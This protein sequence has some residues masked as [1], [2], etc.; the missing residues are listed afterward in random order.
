MCIWK[1]S[2]GLM[3]Q[4]HYYHIKTKYDSKSKLFLTDTDSS[5][6]EIKTEDIYENFRSNKEMFDF[7]NNLTKSKH[8]DVSKKLG[9]NK[10]VIPTISQNKCKDDLLK[11]K[12]MRNSMNRIQSEDYTIETFEIN[13][14]PLPCFDD[15]IYTKNNGYDGLTLV[16]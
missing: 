4:F 13:K 7:S 14:T 12:F 9:L 15:K 1:L 16:Y 6:Y 11:N 8:C 10:Y 2:T 3:Y 5:I